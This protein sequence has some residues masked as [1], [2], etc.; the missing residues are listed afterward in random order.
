MRLAE[1]RD[2][3]RREVERLKEALDAIRAAGERGGSH[4]AARDFVN[5][6]GGFDADLDDEAVLIEVARLAREEGA[7]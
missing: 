6:R 2:A 1:E 7:W 5:K 3:A 4:L